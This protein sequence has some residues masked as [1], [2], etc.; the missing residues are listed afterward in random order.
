[1]PVHN[2]MYH[3][4]VCIKYTAADPGSVLE[5]LINTHKVTN[6]FLKNYFCQQL[7]DI[8]IGSGFVAKSDRKQNSGS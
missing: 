5:Q 6:G 7:S 8:G 3:V 4:Y 2:I 1:M